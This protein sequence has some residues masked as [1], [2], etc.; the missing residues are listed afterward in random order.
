MKWLFK[1]LFMN[2]EATTFLNVEGLGSQSL[3]VKPLFHDH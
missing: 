3:R 1:F 2:K